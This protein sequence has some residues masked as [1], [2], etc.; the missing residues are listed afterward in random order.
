MKY[1]HLQGMFFFRVIFLNILLVVS[2]IGLYHIVEQLM[3]PGALRVAVE[4]LLVVSTGVGVGWLTIGN[5]ERQFGPVL[6]RL[7]KVSGSGAVEDSPDGFEEVVRRV[8][9][10]LSELEERGK[11]GFSALEA[12]REGVLL[13]DESGREMFRNRKW[14]RIM[15]EA[16]GSGVQ[17]CRDQSEIPQVRNVVEKMR[18][19]NRPVGLDASFRGRPFRIE[20]RPAG[21]GTKGYVI[22]VND[23]H[24]QEE[25]DR[26]KRD[27]VAN[28][29]H[30]LKTPLTAV[31]GYIET[32]AEDVPEESTEYIRIIQRQT[33]RLVRIIED[34]ITLNNVESRE[35]VQKEEVDLTGIVNNVKR[36]FKAKAEEKELGFS[37]YVE[38]DLEPVLGDGFQLEQV[39]VNL[40]DNAIKYTDSGTVEVKVEREKGGVLITVRDSGVGIPNEDRERIFERFYVVDKSRSRRLGGTGLGL[41]IVKHI[42][43]AHGG[44]IGMESDLG[45]GTTFS[46]KLPRASRV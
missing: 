24:E 18:T 19:L 41:S 33:D 29:S 3:D 2:C 31:K 1:D 8:E 25:L 26:F 21:E 27:L 35:F 46:V 22:L 42:V 12:M 9:K 6:E 39:L 11:Y 7:Q 36:L 40:V 16:T 43:Q 13:L 38:P 32:L 17:A 23:L 45:R 10:R 30:E 44:E 4:V 5:Y 15:E 34:L 28:V 14:D 37:V 20:G